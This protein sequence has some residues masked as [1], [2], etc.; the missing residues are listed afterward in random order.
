MSTPLRRTAGRTRH[1]AAFLLG[2]G[3][4]L[5]KANLTIAWEILTPRSGLAPAIVE[6]PLRCRTRWEIVSISNLINLTPGTLTV[7]VLTEPPTLYVHGAHAHD[8]AAFRQEL[9]ELETLMLAAFRPADE[10]DELRRST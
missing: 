5:V 8:V 1:V 3:Y 4:R 9:R 7:E 6:V 10:A 2:F